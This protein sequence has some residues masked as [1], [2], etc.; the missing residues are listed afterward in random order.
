MRCVPNENLLFSKRFFLL[1]IFFHWWCDRVQ[2]QLVC[3]PV[4]FC[5]LSFLEKG[6]VENPIYLRIKPCCSPGKIEIFTLGEEMTIGNLAGNHQGVDDDDHDDD[7]TLSDSFLS[8]S[9]GSWCIFN[10]IK[11]FTYFLLACCEEI[12]CKKVLR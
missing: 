3:L 1:Y 12:Q 4:F 6:K 2:V 10:E 11:S 5:F 7:I 8:V 9:P